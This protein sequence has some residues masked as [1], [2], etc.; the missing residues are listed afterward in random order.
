MLIALLSDI[1]DN[2]SSMEAAL[3]RADE[4][5]CRHL[6]FMGDL[7]SLSTLQTMR[8]EWPHPIELVFGNNEIYHDFHLQLA[9]SLPGITHHGTEADIMLDGRHIFFCHYPHVAERQAF[10]GAYDAV[11]YGHTHTA[12]HQQGRHTLLANPGEIQGR[13]GKRSF[14]IYDTSD[15]SLRIIRIP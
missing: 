2:T 3:H 1:H 4:L 10:T 5:G 9:E 7:T 6:L 12:T 14:G 8:E 11:F 15:G 13:T